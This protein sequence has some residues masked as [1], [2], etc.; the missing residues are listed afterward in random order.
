MTMI[1][2]KNKPLS[3][4]LL[5]LTMVLYF[6]WP[7]LVGLIFLPEEL[8]PAVI[9]NIIWALGFFSWFVIN[10]KRMGR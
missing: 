8:Q 1:E 10:D 2:Q 3:D 7:G 9:L 6:N 4:V 5:I